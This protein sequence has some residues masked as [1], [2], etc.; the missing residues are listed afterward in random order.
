MTIIIIGNIL[1][2][3]Q[4]I[5]NLSHRIQY[6]LLSSQIGDWRLPL[7]SKYKHNYFF[8]TLTS[9][10]CRSMTWEVCVEDYQNDSADFNRPRFDKPIMWGWWTQL[11]ATC[12][13][14]LTDSFTKSF[15]CW[16]LFL[17]VLIWEP[18]YRWDIDVDLV[19]VWEA[20]LLSQLWP[21][22]LL[23]AAGLLFYSYPSPPPVRVYWP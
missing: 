9:K 11:S 17:Y 8:R 23:A 13:C 2:I 21:A 20:R 15:R 7:I 1:I 19:L 4:D 10:I 12:R 5:S 16:N 3:L 6:L 14:I 18:V 22:V